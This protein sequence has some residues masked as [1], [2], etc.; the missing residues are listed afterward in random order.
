MTEVLRVGSMCSGYGGLDMALSMVLGHCELQWVCEFAKDP[1]LILAERFPGVPNYG[2]L[3]NHAWETA[4]AIDVLTAGF[5]CQPVSMAGNRKGTADH[6]WIFDDICS[7]VSRMVARPR[8]LVFENVRG[9]LSANRGDAMAR[10]VQGMARIGYVGRYRVL[11]ASAV[12]APHRRERVFIVAWPVEDGASP[13]VDWP[14][15]GRGAALHAL[16]RRGGGGAP[17]RGFTPVPLKAEGLLPTPIAADAGSQELTYKG[18]HKDGAAQVGAP[19]L[20]LL[21]AVT[22]LPTPTAWDAGHPQ[23]ENF[24]RPTLL[25]SLLP[26]PTGEDGSRAS[27]A[28]GREG[29]TGALLPTPTTGDS[30]FE[31]GLRAGSGLTLDQAVGGRKADPAVP[32]D[33]LIPTPTATDATEDRETRYGAGGNLSLLGAVTGGQTDAQKRRGEVLLPTPM[34]SSDHKRDPGEDEQAALPELLQGHGSAPLLPTPKAADGKHGPGSRS[35]KGFSPG[36]GQVVRERLLPTPIVADGRHY[37]PTTRADGDGL[38]LYGA[39]LA[40]DGPLLPTMTA[41]DGHSSDTD[42]PNREGSASLSA[43]AAEGRLLPT[44]IAYD[45]TGK[46][47]PYGS[48]LALPGAVGNLDGESRRPLNEE[49]DWQAE[50]GAALKDAEAELRRFEQDELPGLDRD[51]LMARNV[52]VADE[53]VTHRLG[54]YG[55]AADRWARVV[56]REAPDPTY[57]ED[58]RRRLSPAFGEWMMGL[59]PGWVTDV[60]APRKALRAIGNGVVPQQAAAALLMLLEGAEEDAGVG[61]GHPWFGTFCCICFRRLTAETCVVDVEGQKWDACSGGCAR[62]AGIEEAVDGGA[63]VPEVRGGDAGPV[64]GADLAG[65]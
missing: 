1:S 37:R 40:A 2:D 44:P 59:P 7:A 16:G 20:T 15:R 38:S 23:V 48:G 50:A 13:R 46:E 35:G 62:E 54:V 12:G 64:V 30:Q 36:L 3:I 39:A 21:G 58:G 19:S 63:G 32:T 25:G 61:V 18:S 17:G 28:A 31:R 34:T 14:G 65:G 53:A 56:G 8:L 57:V 22:E 6:R 52:R 33:R 27:D 42:A 24:G 9:L 11:P 4:P 41:H 45:A 29:S 51:V 43:M 26:T 55:P 5:P 60:L 49:D 47:F 10:V